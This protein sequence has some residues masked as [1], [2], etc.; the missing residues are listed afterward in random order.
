MLKQMYQYGNHEAF[1]RQLIE[2]CI[3]PV[4][5]ERQYITLPTDEEYTEAL[6]ETL[7]EIYT[8]MENTSDAA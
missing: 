7:N 4:V 8:E 2:L 3:D 1:A 6:T 5:S